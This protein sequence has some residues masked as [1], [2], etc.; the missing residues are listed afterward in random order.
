MS[1]SFFIAPIVEGHGEVQAVPILL[2]RLAA[3]LTPTAQLHLNPALRVKAGSFLNDNEYFNKYV[4]LAARK[5][6]SWPNSCVMILLD[7]EDTCPGQ[8]GPE[9]LEKAKNCRA[10]V[11][12]I[13]LLAYREYETW[14]LAAARSL[15]GVCGLSDDLEPP[16]NPELFRD[17]KGWLSEKME[18]PYNETNHQPKLTA[19]FNFQEATAVDSFARLFRKL[20][21]F[22]QSD[23]AEDSGGK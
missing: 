6:K 23:I 15:R 19:A 20:H 17:A 1:G 8:L 4:E 10:D 18:F 12:I 13:V 5:T 21:P 2:R 14:F 3:E 9:L 7:S 11:T 22:F 16:N